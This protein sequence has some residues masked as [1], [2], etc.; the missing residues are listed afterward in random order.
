MKTFHPGYTTIAPI[1]IDIIIAIWMEKFPNKSKVSAR[2]SFGALQ[3]VAK[4]IQRGDIVLSP[5]GP[6]AYYIGEVTGDYS[7]HAGEILPQAL[8]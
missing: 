6:E 3:T 8:C 2:L 1:S 7:Y 4:G 5:N